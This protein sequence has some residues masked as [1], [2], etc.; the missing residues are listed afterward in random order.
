MGALNLIDIDIDIDIKVYRT[1]SQNAT[2]IHNI[3]YC[4]KSFQTIRYQFFDVIPL[5]LTYIILRHKLLFAIISNK[6]ISNAC[7]TVFRYSV[8]C[9]ENLQER[10]DIFFFNTFFIKLYNIRHM[11]KAHMDKPTVAHTKTLYH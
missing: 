3:N 5:S 1:C 4:L 8:C 10:N 2:E 11:I 7:Q 6:Y 9:M